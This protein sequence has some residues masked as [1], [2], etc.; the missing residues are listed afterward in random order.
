MSNV[1]IIGNGNVG[2]HFSKRI[3]EN[4]AV[5]IF[6]RSA[7]ESHVKPL[8]T[9]NAQEF[10]FTLITVPDD[11]ISEVSELIKE[12][13]CMI[14]H[15]SG[16]CPLSDLSKHRK[17]GVI[18][19]LQTFSKEKEIDFDSF[20]IFLE[21]S[22]EAKGEI[23]AFVKTFSSDVRVANSS[24]RAKIH[25]AAVFAC[26]FANHMYA[27][28]D[29]ILGQA[30]MSFQDLHHLAKETLDKAV[31]MPPSKAQTGPAIRNDM[32]TISKH[33]KMIDSKEVKKIYE[34]ISKDIRKAHQ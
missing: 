30:G 32:E 2:N 22:D 14:V 31:S 3:S 33:I 5:S 1:A 25:L 9:Y 28:S 27:I 34:L 10:D 15:T 20:P 12:S 21:E 7:Q 26:N 23:S 16:S 13:N 24:Q 4:H 6:S 29:S 18:Y 19:P 8:R 17:S 11:R